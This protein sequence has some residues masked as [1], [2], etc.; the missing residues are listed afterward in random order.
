MLFSIAATK[1]LFS[2]NS[3]PFFVNNQNFEQSPENL[4]FVK[5]FLNNLLGRRDEN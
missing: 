5:K 1:S 3:T 4:K 2:S